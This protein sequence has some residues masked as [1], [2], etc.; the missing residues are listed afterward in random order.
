MSMDQRGNLHSV[1]EDGAVR[2]KLSVEIYG[3]QYQLTGKASPSHMRQVAS[4]VDEK[5]RQIAD[6]NPRLDVAA[7]PS[8]RR[9]ILRMII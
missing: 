8:C 1:K 2:N 5:M 6:N 3:T 7:W 4:H 9:S